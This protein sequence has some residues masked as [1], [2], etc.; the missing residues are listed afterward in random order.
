MCIQSLL[1][2]YR[3]F[4]SANFEGLFVLRKLETLQFFETDFILQLFI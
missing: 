2:S 3:K 4:W 1:P